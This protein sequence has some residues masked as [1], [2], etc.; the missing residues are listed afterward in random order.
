MS[1]TV[2]I[3]GFSTGIQYSFLRAAHG[4]DAGFSAFASDIQEG[5]VSVFRWDIKENATFW[6][7]INPL[8]TFGVYRREQKIVSEKETHENLQKF[9]EQEKPE[10]VVCH[11]I[12]CLLFLE[13][14][15]TQ[16]LPSSVK[17]VIFNQAD[18]TW[19]DIELPLRIEKQIQSKTLQFI[20]TYCPWDPTLMFSVF[21]GG[22]L[23][24]GLVG[25]RHSHIE[26]IFFALTKPYNLHTSA[27]RS[28]KFRDWVIR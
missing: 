18:T 7:S 21:V 25:I 24:A 26:N 14:I 8:Y 9:L 27:I 3:H 20:N 6:Q 15:K 19:F 17:R 2:L 16:S 11:S 5:K 10:I 12:G 28:K 13:Y 1:R 4:F 23:R 22:A